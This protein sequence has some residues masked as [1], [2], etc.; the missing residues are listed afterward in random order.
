MPRSHNNILDKL[1]FNRLRV[2]LFFVGKYHHFANFSILTIAL[3]AWA[4]NLVRSVY[5]LT[6][7]D[8]ARRIWMLVTKTSL[9]LF[10]SSLVAG[11][12]LLLLLE[13]ALACGLSVSF[14]CFGSGS[15]GRMLSSRGKHREVPVRYW[16]TPQKSGNH[17]LELTTT[18]VQ[19]CRRSISLLQ[20]SEKHW[21]QCQLKYTWIYLHWA[22]VPPR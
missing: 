1:N 17:Q 2:Q 14:G 6:E 19:R 10:A 21:H 7:L 5:R 22:N 15:L 12:P 11:T 16:C 4:A 3:I 8:R 20:S 18:L 13:V 9:L